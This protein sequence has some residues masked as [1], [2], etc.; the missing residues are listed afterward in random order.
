MT[1]TNSDSAEVVLV[2]R[3]TTRYGAGWWPAGL[4]QVAKVGSDR[5]VVSATGAATLYRGGY[6]D[7]Y[8]PPPGVFTA[9]VRTGSTFELRPRGSLAR[10]VFDTTGRLR[11][12]VDANGNRDSVAYSGTSDQVTAFVDPVGK[13][14]TLSY[15]GAGRLSAWS[16]PAGRQSRVTIDGSNRL[17]YDS[18]SSPGSK[19]NVTRFVYQGYPGVGTYV[20]A[21]RLGVVT[22]TTVVTYDSTFKRRPSQVRLP[23]VQNE[24]G[25][26]VNPVIAY[27]AVERQGYGALRSLDSLYVQVTDP[28][29]NW[30]RSTL[31]RWSQTTRTWDTLGLLARASYTEQGLPRWSEGKSGD[32]SRVYTDHDAAWRLARSY[33]VRGAGDTLRLDSLVYDANHRVVQRVDSRGKVSTTGYDAKGNV[34]RTITPRNDTT[35]IAYRADGLVDHTQLPGD[36]ATTRFVYDTVWKNLVSTVDRSGDTL[37]SA[38]FDNLG[39]T[40]ESMRRVR[41]GVDLSDI[42]P[43]TYYKDRRTQ[44]WFNAANQVD[45]VRLMARDD[46]GAWPSPGDTTLVQR[47]SYRYDRAGRDSLR[48]R[49]RGYGER[50][51]YDR[52]GRVVVY[53]PYIN[54]AA[55]SDSAALVDSTWYDI[56]GNV[57]KART[58]RGHL[59]E[60]T[61]DSRNRPDSTVIPTVGTLRRAYGGPLD[62]LTRLWIAGAV[63]SLGG[64]NGERRWG[65]DE[66]GRLAADT[67]YAGTTVR[68]TGYTYDTHERLSSYANVSGTWMHRYE[69]DRGLLDTVITPY[70]GS[71]R[72]D[73]LIYKYDGQGRINGPTIRSQISSSYTSATFGEMAVRGVSY[74]LTG[75]AR[76]ITTTIK[77]D[78]WTGSS[79]DFMNGLMSAVA[80]E[81]A[82]PFLATKWVRRPGMTGGTDTLLYQPDYDGWHRL[83]AQT[84]RKNGVAQYTESY[85]FDRTGNVNQPTGAAVYDPFTDR[86]VQRTESGGTR[87]FRYD[88]AGNL[89]A[90]SVSGTVR[91]YSYDALNRLVT[92]RQNGTLIARYAYD[93]EGR[94]IA[95][96]VYTPT[97]GGIDAYTRF[98]YQG[99]HVQAES[100]SVGTLTL[101][102]V[103]GLGTDDLI[104][105][106]SVAGTYGQGQYYA[107]LDQLGSVRGLVRWSRQWN[108]GATYRPYGEAVIDSLK[109]WVRYRWTGREYDTETGL[110]YFRARY[111]APG[112][113]RFI[114]ADPIGHAGSGNLYAYLDGQP[115]EGRDPSGME[116]DNEYFGGPAP[117][118]TCSSSCYLAQSH[119]GYDGLPHWVHPFILEG[120][121]GFNARLG[122]EEYLANAV[123]WQGLAADGNM[124]SRLAPVVHASSPLTLKQYIKLAAGLAVAEHWHTIGGGYDAEAVW[125]VDE[126]ELIL[127]EGRVFT[128]DA[129]VAARARLVDPLA[130]GRG[131]ALGPFI[132]LASPIFRGDQQC[133]A[134]TMIHEALHVKGRSTVG[135]LPSRATGCFIPSQH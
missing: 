37:G 91:H 121:A 24:T 41:T 9:L 67:A 129:Y 32:S 7:H 104:A 43:V 44:T 69:T 58:R 51:L 123:E 101:R 88:R 131:S 29:G 83:T 36:T 64:V 52:L 74:N 8:L 17:T 82:Q 110:Y 16:D 15:D 42:V 63:D 19:G 122:Y 108:S 54:P 38:T 84:F 76:Q 40:V 92:A 95:K 30:T 18:L 27:A 100:D 25:T 133:V 57:R 126:A 62:Q 59:I 89:T 127:R 118:V 23:R 106:D 114:Q 70:Y 81:D 45:S 115:T 80:Q 14:V 135:S 117:N 97:T 130:E 68:A 78:P 11:T 124:D 111:Y 22:D 107:V 6:G 119:M 33:I 71:G 2:D 90:D 10:V 105:I 50:W 113:R 12:A 134:E 103:W 112:L 87:Y 79:H 46:G 66:R 20:L 4:S 55:V 1:K 61:Y 13:A 73:T 26:W 47:V 53:R 102:Y 49:N 116:K 65:Y 120:V 72:R 94:R 85:T 21:K 96:R 5:I 93:V 77:R 56:A 86:L 60:T 128:N 28:R 125:V 3:R 132:F 34:I 39:R 109:S 35:L 48:L 98:I 99:A 75:I 31:N